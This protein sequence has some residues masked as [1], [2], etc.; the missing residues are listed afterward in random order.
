MRIGLF[1]DDYHP[2]VDGVVV[3]ID[4]ISKILTKLGHEVYIICP[5]YP[6]HNQSKGKVIRVSSYDPLPFSKLTSR[7]MVTNRKTLKTIKDLDLDVIH[8]HTQ[9]GANFTAYMVAKENGTK[10]IT[11][12]HTTYHP[13]IDVYPGVT[14]VA[15]VMGNFLALRYYHDTKAFRSLLTFPFPLKKRIAYW[16]D[17][18]IK[19]VLDH[20]D[21]VITNSNHAKAYVEDFGSTTETEIIRNGVDRSWFKPATK[22]TQHPKILHFVLTSRLSGEKRQE[23]AIK[24]L[25]RLISKGHEYRLT[26]VGGGPMRKNYEKLIKSLGIDEYVT[27]TGEVER[28]SVKAALDEADVALFT[29]YHFDTDPLAVMEYLAMGLPVIYCDENF[30]DMFLKGAAIKSGRDAGSFARA[31]EDLILNP[32]QLKRMSKLARESSRKHDIYEKVKK[33]ERV[34][35]SVLSTKSD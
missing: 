29:S 28:E 15:V 27:I 22:K 5:K 20:S 30:E 8:A 7:M 14:L 11:T 1:T 25:A 19:S 2:R 34:Y 31:M 23:V 9:A 6:G 32:E 10:L 17:I 26:L 21:L 24:A 3:Y 35:G 13:L 33:L 12:M 4:A 18:Y 16:T